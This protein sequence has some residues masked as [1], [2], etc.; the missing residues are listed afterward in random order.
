MVQN[1]STKPI[2]YILNIINSRHNVGGIS[3]TILLASTPI[4]SLWFIVMLIKNYRTL[5][6]ML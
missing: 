2:Q 1:L 4:S 5:H 6:S 3:G